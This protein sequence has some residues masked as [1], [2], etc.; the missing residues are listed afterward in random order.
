MTERL[1]PTRLLFRFSVPCLYRESLWTAEGAALGAEHRLP[2]LTQLDEGRSYAD[3]RA[4]WSEAG[5]SFRVQV[6]GK[7]QQPWCRE[8]RPDESDGLRIWIDTRDT[9][10]I[11]RASRFCHQFVF[12]PLGSGRQ[13]ADPSAEPLLINRAKENAKPVRPGVLRVRSEKRVDGYVLDAHIPA[14]ALT[15]FDPAEH[16]RLGFTYA[17]IDREL[18]N[19]TFSC[20]GEFSYQDDPSLWASLE[21]VRPGM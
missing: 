13:L 3:V 4:A 16:P 7:R 8:A 2:S 18:G 21:L 5:L 19:Q 10:S 14:A 12:L 20:G 11:H 17:M 15:G 1:L 9:H 6:E